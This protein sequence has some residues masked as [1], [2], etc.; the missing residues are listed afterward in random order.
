MNTCLAVKASAL[1]NCAAPHIVPARVS[2]T[3]PPVTSKPT[4]DKLT[5]ILE[6]RMDGSVQVFYFMAVFQKDPRYA[7]PS[8]VITLKIGRLFSVNNGWL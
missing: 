3:S 4:G 8:L 7:G 6:Q 5:P 1:T 2:D